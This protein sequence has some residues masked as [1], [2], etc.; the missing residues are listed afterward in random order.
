MSKL[1]KR[2]LTVARRH[3]FNVY[4]YFRS[5]DMG[6]PSQAVSRWSR[7]LG[8]SGAKAASL[9]DETRKDLGLPPRSIPRLVYQRFILRR[10]LGKS[11]VGSFI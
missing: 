11:P 10:R 1:S 2:A 8:R 5:I 7:K 4:W 6:A 9:I 3:N